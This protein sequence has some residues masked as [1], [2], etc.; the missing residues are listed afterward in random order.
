MPAIP[1]YQKSSTFEK[2]K[3]IGNYGTQNRTKGCSDNST[4]AAIGHEEMLSDADLLLVLNKP[5]S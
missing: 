2:P 4:C 3:S 1:L 5:R